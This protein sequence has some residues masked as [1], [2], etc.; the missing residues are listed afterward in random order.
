MRTVRPM[1]TH[2]TSLS[3]GL[4]LQPIVDRKFEVVMFEALARPDGVAPEILA[5][6]APLSLLE[7]QINAVQSVDLY[8]L[9][10]VEPETLC[11]APDRVVELFSRTRNVGIEV[12]ERGVLSRAGVSALVELHKLGVPVWLD[13]FGTGHSTLQ[14]RHEVIQA[15]AVSGVKVPV[16]TQ[17][18][19][20]RLAV[21]DVPVLC[22]AV[23]DIR[24]A[25]TSR[26]DGAELFQGYVFGVPEMLKERTTLVVRSLE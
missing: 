18:S 24:T 8:V 21:P 11:T 23:E 17:V 6:L 20:V 19:Q 10:N 16:G 12:T 25:L 5:Q 2:E 3:V 7:Q 1:H 4:A 26:D 9:L 15:K 13:D 22:E 14:G